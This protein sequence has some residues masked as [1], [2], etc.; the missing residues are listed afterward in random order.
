MI[1][2][3]RGKLVSAT[4]TQAIVD[5][6][7]VGYELAIPLSSVDKL[8]QAG[9]DVRILVYYHV[10][11]MEGMPQ[12]YGFMT[13]GE[14]EL[15]RLLISVTKVGPK[16]ALLIL[17]GMSAIALKGAIVSNDVKSLSKIK[18]VGAKTAERLCVELR[19]KIGEIGGLEAA[20][21]KHALTA[22]EQKLNDAI[23]AMISLGYKQL[24]AHKA[25]RAAMERLGPS[26]TVEELVRQ[27]L[28]SA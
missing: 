20:G 1:S 8:P 18:G 13:E 17:G 26:A 15:F 21:A 12:L 11:A 5:C 3:L 19:D 28:K 14:R 4:P 2:F 23:L 10:V 16:A 25:I 27:A 9:G 6:N 7:G 22:E 24:E